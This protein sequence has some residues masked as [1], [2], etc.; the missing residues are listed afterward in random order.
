MLR[1][2]AEEMDS[3]AHGS[4][5]VK[6]PQRRYLFGGKEES[7]LGQVLGVTKGRRSAR[8]DGDLEQGVGVFKVPATDGV[9]CLVICDRLL[10]FFTQDTRF[11]L[12]AWA[13]RG[14]EMK[15][16]NVGQARDGSGAVALLSGI[17]NAPAMTRSIAAS[18]WLSS[19]DLAPWRAAISAASLQTLARSAPEN[20]GVRVAI[21]FATS[22]LSISVCRGLRCTLKMSRR[23]WK[24]FC[25]TGECVKRVRQ[26]L[27]VCHMLNVQFES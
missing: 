21:F 11:L 10:L 12:Q 27:C 25:G 13:E 7:L 16:R 24:R 14:G 23:P 5:Q 9:S 26:S 6:R 22:S 20:P 8:D 18:K 15:E 1:W 19:I 2:R 4:E 17:A 3:G